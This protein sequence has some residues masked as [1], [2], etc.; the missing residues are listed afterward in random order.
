MWHVHKPRVSHHFASTI[1]L[2]YYLRLIVIYFYDVRACDRLGFCRWCDRGANGALLGESA[3]CGNYDECWFGQVGHL[4][5]YTGEC[6]LTSRLLRYQFNIVWCYFTER[7]I[8]PPFDVKSFLFE[9]VV[10]CLVAA[11]FLLALYIWWRY[12]KFGL[13]LPLYDNTTFYF[14][15]WCL[16]TVR[17]KRGRFDG[18]FVYLRACILSICTCSDTFSS[19]H[20]VYCATF[21]ACST[22]LALLV[23]L[24]NVLL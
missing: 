5:P 15:T 3:Y 1:L 11:V 17:R 12:K 23:V 9:A 21:D 14:D 4:D 20:H 13:N 22:L 18:L 6:D 2:N 7:R 10:T 24:V 16:F 19:C 8:A